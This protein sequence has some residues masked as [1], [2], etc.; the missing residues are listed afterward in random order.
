[1]TTLSL[2]STVGAPI[3]I[4][5]EPPLAVHHAHHLRTPALPPLQLVEVT[6]VLEVA[7][8]TLEVETHLPVVLFRLDAASDQLGQVVLLLLPLR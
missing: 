3:V 6:V 1:M 8:L 5:F 4:Q 7:L 2:A